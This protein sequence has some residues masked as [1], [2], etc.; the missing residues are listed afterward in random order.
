MGCASISVLQWCGLRIETRLWM[1]W[2]VTQARHIIA[3][4]DLFFTTK[5]LA[6]PPRG[7][8][9][10]DR[11]CV[12]QGGPHCYPDHSKDVGVSLT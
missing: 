4:G 9:A 5:A 12:W 6:S 8:T 2:E 3:Y 7:A 1:G 11:V 10:I